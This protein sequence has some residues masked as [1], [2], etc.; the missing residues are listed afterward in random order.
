MFRCFK[1]FHSTASLQKLCEFVSN[2]ERRTKKV[3]ASM[4]YFSGFQVL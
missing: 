1:V 3:T 2:G 4:V